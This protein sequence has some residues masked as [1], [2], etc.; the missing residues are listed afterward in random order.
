[1]KKN[2]LFSLIVLSILPFS[3]AACGSQQ[4]S[5][6]KKDTSERTSQKKSSVNHK[7]KIA[8]SKTSNVSSSNY[9]VSSTKIN[10]KSQTTTSNVISSASSSTSDTVTMT[11]QDAKNLVK[12]H[13]VNQ[14]NIRG[15]AGK[16]TADLPSVDSIDSYSAIQN[17]VNDWTI[18]GNGHSFHVTDKA[19]VGN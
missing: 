16:S 12:S 9:S 3:L 14:F 18:S 7:T 19:I 2:K 4:T 6:V 8:S 1:M 17:G 10:N 15:E 5:N 11:A 13:I